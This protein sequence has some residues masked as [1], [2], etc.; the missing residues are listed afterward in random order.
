M[1]DMHVQILFWQCTNNC[2]YILIFPSEAE[3]ERAA[4]DQTAGAGLGREWNDSTG[5]GL[6]PEE[7]I[8]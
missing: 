7:A 5:P 2:M 6:F 1:N 8:L 3:K 4:T